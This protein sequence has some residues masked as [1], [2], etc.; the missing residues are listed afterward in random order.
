MKLA[1]QAVGQKQ[2]ELAQSEK[3]FLA[4]YQL[5]PL[6]ILLNRFDDGS[7]VEA[8]PAME[9]L[10]GYSLDELRQLSFKDLTPAHFV[11]SEKEQLKSLAEVGHYG[12]YI[13]QY[14]HKNGELIDIELNGVLFTESSGE[15]FIWTIIKDIRDVKRVEKLKDDF[16]ST[17]SHELRTPLTSIAG[18]LGL[19]LGGA[20]GPI[21]DK[22]EKLLSIA[23][24]NSQ[25]LNLL[26]N[27]LLDF[28]KLIAGKMRFE[29]AAIELRKFLEDVIEQHQPLARQQGQQL[30]LAPIPKAKL[31]VDPD[32][33]A[34]VLSNYLS[35]AIKF[36]PEHS[37][38]LVGADLSDN[39]VRIWVQDNGPG[40]SEPDQAKLFQRFSQLENLNDAK[41]GTGLG[42]A[43]SREIATRSGGDVGVTSQIGE[44]ARFWLQLPLYNEKSANHADSKILVI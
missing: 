19:V 14:R 27:D 10:V 23:H 4:L 24:K 15:K 34:Q 5:S 1:K 17:V 38:V 21:A 28:D 36:S 26:I 18:A 37:T 13:K 9:Q 40:I 16:V 2:A 8:N 6:P 42:L 30:N 20:A 35:N 33:I 44:G 22:A 39:L 29:P 41:G 32:R 7:Y 12:P 3:K 43:I 25:R 31:W 11:A